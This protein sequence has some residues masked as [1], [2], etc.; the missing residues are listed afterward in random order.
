MVSWLATNSD[1][2]P[3]Y[4]LGLDG[5]NDR[6]YTPLRWPVQMRANPLFHSIRSNDVTNTADR[7]TQYNGTTLVTFSSTYHIQ[8][9]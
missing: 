2:G 3:Y 1:R 6:A 8:M 9:G 4:A 5:I 7:I